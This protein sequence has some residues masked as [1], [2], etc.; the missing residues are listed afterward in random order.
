MVVRLTSALIIATIG[1][2]LTFV[3]VSGFAGSAQDAFKK[4]QG[5]QNGSG[6]KAHSASSAGKATG[7]N[8]SKKEKTK[9]AMNDVLN[10][11]SKK[12]QD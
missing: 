5:Q 1:G 6:I 12:S 8:G 10:K 11:G 4:L 3:P 7:E 2:T 9:K